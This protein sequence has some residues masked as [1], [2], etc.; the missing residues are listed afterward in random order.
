[1]LSVLA[2]QDQDDPTVQAIADRAGVSVGSVYQY[3]P[4]KAAL[5][6]QLIRYHLQDRMNAL[7][8]S[9]SAAQGLS[10]EAAAERLVED[11]LGEKRARS[12][13]ETAMLRYF[14]RAGDLASLTE[15]DERMLHLVKRF[16]SSLGPAIRPVNLDTAA[17]V[18]SNS[19]RS[20]ILLSL[21]QQPA[22]LADADFKAELVR[23]VVGYLKP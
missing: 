11:L 1:M 9:L 6:S 18:I 22:R 17:F 15:Q 21:L 16:L 23:L 7:E 13:I 12:R 3:F 2:R 4:T 19:L 20:A 5:V 8:R 10:G 14:M